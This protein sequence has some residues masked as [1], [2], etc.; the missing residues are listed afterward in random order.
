MG[1]YLDNAATSYPKPEDVYLAVDDFQRN[2]GASP[3]RGTYRK[4]RQADQIVFETRSN[5]ASLF[6]IDDVTRIIFTAH[7]S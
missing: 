2:V 1:I 4:A 5:L 7:S 3:G 6:N